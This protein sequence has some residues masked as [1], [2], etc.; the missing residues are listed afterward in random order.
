[1]KLDKTEK[2]HTS[3]HKISNSQMPQ[4]SLKKKSNFPGRKLPPK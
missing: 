2:L 1:M 4:V 3:F